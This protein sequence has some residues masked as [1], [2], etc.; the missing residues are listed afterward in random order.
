IAD[1]GKIHCLPHARINHGRGPWVVRYERVSVRSSPDEF[2][3]VIHHAAQLYAGGFTKDDI[4]SGRPHP[5]K[6]AKHGI[7]VWRRHATPLVPFVGGPLMDL[8]VALLRKETLDD[9]IART[10]RSP[11][12]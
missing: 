9:L 4:T 1:S 2:A 12:A 11:D 3:H 7:D 10:D 5:S 8:A 6:L